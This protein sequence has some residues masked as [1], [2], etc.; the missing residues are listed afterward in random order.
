MRD[1]YKRQLQTYRDAAALGID[2]VLTS[3]AAASCVQGVDV[4]C[5]LLA[6]RD[7]PT[8]HQQCGAKQPDGV[9]LRGVLPC[10]GQCVGAG[11]A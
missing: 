11:N 7:L 10:G 8:G 4:L 2:T 6:E 9:R 5:S 3:G 1:V